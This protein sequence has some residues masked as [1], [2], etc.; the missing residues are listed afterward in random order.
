MLVDP[1]LVTTEHVG[2][3]HNDASR[4]LMS[5]YRHL[6][7]LTWSGCSNLERMDILESTYYLPML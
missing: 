6:W 4:L 5:S 3:E 2:I 7:R 1:A